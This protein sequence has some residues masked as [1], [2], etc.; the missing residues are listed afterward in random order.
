MHSYHL[1]ELEDGSQEMR[2]RDL[3][4]LSELWKQRI[5]AR[6]QDGN[7]RNSKRNRISRNKNP[8]TRP[9]LILPTKYPGSK[10]TTLPPRP[11]PE[12]CRNHSKVS[13]IQDEAGPVVCL[14]RTS[15]QLLKQLES[16]GG[17]I[18][19]Y[20]AVN[21]SEAC[22]FEDLTAFA[23]GEPKKPA[24]TRVPEVVTKT[25]PTKLRIKRQGETEDSELQFQRPKRS[26]PT[27]P[28]TF[29]RGCQ[30]R[31][32]I[33]DGTNLHRLCTECA[34]TTR[35]NDDRFPN[36]I[37][38][39]ICQDEDHQCAAKMGQCFQ[40][41]LEL[42]FLRFDGKFEQD[43][44]LSNLAGKTVYREVWESYTQPIRS[45]CEC[46]MYPFIYHVIASRDDGDGNESDDETS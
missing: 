8:W 41:T 22:S 33:P 18:K 37:N 20:A 32:T 14:R 26:L 4:R 27:S 2:N 23:N 45:C 29:I 13:R 25:E 39:V 43:D 3:N 15:K 38:E 7:L 11:G 40:R 12:I 21:E 35:L 16:V 1:V 5:I 24:T 42:S 44:R 6:R 36:F 9:T 30:G 28:G 31:G 46:E 17:F 10:A 34:A 19:R